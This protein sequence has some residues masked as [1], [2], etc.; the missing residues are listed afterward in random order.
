MKL[1]S[2]IACLEAFHPGSG[3][4]FEGCIWVRTD[5]PTPD[6][7]LWVCAETGTTTT[8]QELA[9]KVCD[10]RRCLNN[11]PALPDLTTVNV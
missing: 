5:Y 11:L 3:Y 2:M 1:A 4:C 9:E 6:G 10:D 7:A 8:T